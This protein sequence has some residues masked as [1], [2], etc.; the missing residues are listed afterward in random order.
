V[1][2]SEGVGGYCVLEV[3]VLIE[4]EEEVDNFTLVV[5]LDDSGIKYPDDVWVSSQTVSFGMGSTMCANI[6]EAP[7]S[8]YLSHCL[9]NTILACRTTNLLECK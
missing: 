6:P 5:V 3:A 8:L 4:W 9:P 1:G 7:I 2:A